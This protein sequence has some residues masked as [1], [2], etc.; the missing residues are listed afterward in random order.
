MLTQPYYGV[1]TNETD[2]EPA[3]FWISSAGNTFK[4]N[5]AVGGMSGFLQEIR[6]VRNVLCLTSQLTSWQT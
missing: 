1:P 6:T 5:V 3:I 2:N 4:D